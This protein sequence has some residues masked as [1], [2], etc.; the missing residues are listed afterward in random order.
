M[1]ITHLLGGTTFALSVGLASTFGVSTSRLARKLELAQYRGIE[2]SAAL[3][4]D[5]SL[6][7][8][9]DNTLE[10]EPDLAEVG[11]LKTL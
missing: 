7:A 10:L 11:F 1:K 9:A 6:S 2:F 4:G 3:S 8:L 5:V